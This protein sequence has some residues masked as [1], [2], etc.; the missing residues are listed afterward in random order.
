MHDVQ[1]KLY[2]NSLNRNSIIY[3]PT[4]TGK[5]RVAICSMFYYLSRWGTQ[6]KIVFL[7]NT[8]QLV[9]QQAE[10]I[11][12][13]LVR[14]LE[15]KTFA[16]TLRSSLGEDYIELGWTRSDIG[17]HVSCIHGEKA[18]DE[19]G[20]TKRRRIESHC[21]REFLKTMAESTIIVMISQM[22]LNSLRRG[23]ASLTDF[24]FVVF[25]ECHHCSGDHPYSGIMKEFYFDTKEKIAK[26]KRNDNIEL[27]V[28][29]GLTASPIPQP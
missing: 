3:L 22:F 26:H 6:K 15:E 2:Q 18:E 27:P 20:M 5:T 19:L 4:G 28:L 7:A 14:L 13:T 10:A 16:K 23:Y 25:D 17:R 12:E 11:K 9:K 8:V 24:C 1:W 21:T 29:M